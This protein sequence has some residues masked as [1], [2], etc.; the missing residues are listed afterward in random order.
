MPS[1]TACPVTCDVPGARPAHTS[2]ETSDHSSLPVT[3]AHGSRG[4]VST[5]ITDN[6]MEPIVMGSI[7]IQNLF[8]SL[9]QVPFQ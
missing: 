9:V 3:Y 4:H 6:I 5:V 1:V 8:I 7:S 2:A